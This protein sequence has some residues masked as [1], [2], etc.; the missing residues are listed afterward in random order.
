[1]ILSPLNLE[2]LVLANALGGKCR[3]NVLKVHSVVK[4]GEGEEDVEEGSIALE[5]EQSIGAML[6]M[7][8]ILPPVTDSASELVNAPVLVVMNLCISMI[9]MYGRR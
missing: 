5:A 9:F 4:S 7:E 2:F 8:P 3:V 1:M 6:R